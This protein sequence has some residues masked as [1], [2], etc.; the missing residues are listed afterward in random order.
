[1]LITGDKKHHGT[2]RLLVS[3]FKIAT[4]VFLKPKSPWIRKFP[5]L[6]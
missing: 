2:V 3:R 6:Q 4:E 1:M 5:E